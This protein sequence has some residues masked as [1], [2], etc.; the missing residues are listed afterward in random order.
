MKS[1][2][3]RNDLVNNSKYLKILYAGPGNLQFF[4]FINEKNL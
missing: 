4:I 2:F 1:N 3:K